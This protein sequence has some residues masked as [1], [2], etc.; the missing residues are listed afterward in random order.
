MSRIY[1]ATVQAH[2]PDGSL[3]QPG[4]HY[5]VD[6]PGGGSE[7]PAN[8]VADSIWSKWGTA[9]LAACTDQTHVDSLV[10]TEMVVPPDIGAA[11]AHSVNAN[12][13]MSIAD[14]DLPAGLVPILNIH[15]D[16]RSRSARGYTVMPCPY[17]VTKLHLGK[18]SSAFLSAL[19]TLTALLDDTI[20]M[21]GTFPPTLV[22][23]VYSRARHLRDDEPFAFNV[24]TVV[25][26]ATPHWRRSRMTVP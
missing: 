15:S 10:V 13:T 9:F 4:F 25:A 17:G 12:G 11:G 19:G 20:T 18:W 23:V 2:A 6:V 21:G 14:T 1:K 26:N 7:P 16:T 5:K 22:P 8:D 3:V 24:N